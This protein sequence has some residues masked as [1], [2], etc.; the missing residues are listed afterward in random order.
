[1][2]PLRAR[3]KRRS[4]ALPILAIA[5]FAVLTLGA[6]SA[7]L[8]P[9][10]AGS[11]IGTGG[12]GA[13]TNPGSGSP[14][15]AVASSAPAA[16]ADPDASPERDHEL[17]PGPGILALSGSACP[18]PTGQPEPTLR[19]GAGV[20]SPPVAAPHPRGYAVVIG[21]S[22]SSGWAGVGEG[23]NSWPSIL[24]RAQDWRITNLAVPGTGFVNPGWTNDPVRTQVAAAINLKPGIVIV[25]SGHNDER[26]AASTVNRAADVALGRLRTGLP[27][28]MIVV[29][30]PIWPDSDP[31]PTIVA[32]RDHLR[33]TA[34]GIDA[35]FIDPIAGGWFSGANHKYV[36]SDGTHPTSAG[37]R[38]IATL[39][40]AAFR[41]DPR[42]AATPLPAVEAVATPPPPTPAPVPP[43]T[44]FAG[45]GILACA[46]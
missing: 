15:A 9:G 38:R 26:Y 34:A 40:I 16:S 42:L 8:P 33:G 11:T 29:V 13:A 31:D 23:S 3:R 4:R 30:G 1:M 39:L 46:G 44:V 35:L 25:A 32:L 20:V 2:V 37:Y 45:G 12:G 24:G 19:P 6:V 27:N 43:D 14:G 5:T 22:Y 28:A 41:S 36:G 7:L 17:D 18:D 21:D 10:G